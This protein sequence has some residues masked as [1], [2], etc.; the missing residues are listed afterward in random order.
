MGNNGKRLDYIDW[1]E[2]FMAVAALA[3]KRSKDPH[4]QVGACIVNQQNKIVST[5]YNGFPIG[6]SDDEFPWRREGDFGT[7]KYAY[8]CHAELN[9][10]LNN[11]GQPLQGCRIYVVL[12]PCN[13]C[14]KAII[15]TG[16]SEVVYLSD[17]YAK[18]PNMQ[19][20]RRMLEA[21]GV[22]LRQLI[23]THKSLTVSFDVD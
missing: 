7:T 3:A 17:K 12:F 19:A 9:A 8:V 18:E 13:E 16:I 6:C 15:Q 22:K 23:A 14:A 10:I 20:S 1:D 2:Y 11:S 5:G 21:A 4:T